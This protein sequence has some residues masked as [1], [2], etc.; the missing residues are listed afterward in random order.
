M[1][2]ILKVA[3]FILLLL[4]FGGIIA[5]FYLDQFTFAFTLM[6]LLITVLGVWGTALSVKN[7][8]RMHTDMNKTNMPHPDPVKEYSR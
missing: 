3:A 5:G 1:K 8:T 4:T 7:S 2:K 6:G